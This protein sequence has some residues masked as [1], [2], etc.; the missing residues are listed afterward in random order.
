MTHWPL[1]VLTPADDT[2]AFANGR[3]STPD[4][5]LWFGLEP[6]DGA[7]MSEV[8]VVDDLDLLTSHPPLDVLPGLR[9]WARRTGQSIVVTL[10]EE[11][12]LDGGVCAPALMRHSEV[13]LRVQRT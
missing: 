3:S 11:L 2:W 4:A 12:V 6:C 9:T 7:P 5:A 8:L 1:N 10:P 13:V